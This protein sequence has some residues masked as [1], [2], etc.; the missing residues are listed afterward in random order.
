MSDLSKIDL[1]DDAATE[2]PEAVDPAQNLLNDGTVDG[3]E[4]E[5]YASSGTYY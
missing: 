4:T 3:S 1:Q 2:V 5:E